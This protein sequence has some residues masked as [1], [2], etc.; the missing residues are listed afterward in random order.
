M[1][2]QGFRRGLSALAVFG[3]TAG[4]TLVPGVAAASGGGGCGGPVTD[5]TGTSVD[6]NDFCFTPT[7]LRA[8]PGDVVTF[9]NRDRTQHT[10]LGANGIWGGYDTLKR[11]V[12]TT[13]EFTEPGIYPYVCTWHPGMIGVVV[14]GDGA[15]GAID[16]TTAAGP[17]TQ[18]SSQMTTGLSAATTGLESGGV[19]LALAGGAFGFVLGAAG[20]I[21]VR[22]IRRR[23]IA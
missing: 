8:A 23:P 9:T 3:L 20:A 1:E 16:A 18:G 13:F 19:G 12:E 11:G 4:L 17:V 14:V 10:V 22:R 2:R 15:G 7:I 5:G 6:I 21:A